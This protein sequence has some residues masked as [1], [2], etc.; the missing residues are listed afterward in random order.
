MIRLSAKYRL[1]IS[2]IALVCFTSIAMAQLKT[3]TDTFFLAKK[4][5]LWG[6]LGKSI[7]VSGEIPVSIEATVKKNEDNF[8]RFKGKII[9]SIHVQKLD[10]NSSI[11]DT[12]SNK[13]NFFNDLG[14]FLHTTTSEKIIKRNLFFKTGDTLYPALLA[15]NERFLRDISYLQDAKILIKENLVF[16]NEVD[17]L[18]LCKDVFPI[19]G[20]ADLGSEKMLN[21]EIND[22]NLAGRG[23]RIAIKNLI[24][25]DR[26]PYFG[27]G[28]QYLK[29]NFLGSFVNISLGVIN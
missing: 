23:D 29:R 24:D 9:H 8:S 11:N 4:N 20:S 27:I 1:F 25:L 6:K 3:N 13:H 2:S 7:S 22:D 14:N 17:V 21:F 15:D 10:F 18:I 12:S 19:G 5:G 26:T 28:G 16:K